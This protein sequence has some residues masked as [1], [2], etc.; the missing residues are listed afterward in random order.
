MGQASDLTCAARPH[1]SIA[2]D[3]IELSN[4]ISRAS[5]VLNQYVREVREARAD[6]DAVSRELHSLQSTLELLKEDA[7]ALPSKVATETPPLL[8]QCNRVVGELDADLLAL[9]GS[10]LSRP[11]KRAQWVSVG[12]HQIKELLPAI[13][14]HR[15]ILA[16]ALD[17]ITM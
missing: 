9:D 16:L 8:Q 7:G 4:T 2:N 6:L 14:V 5:V 10:A 12:K 3:C 1:S 17:L 11:Q 13:A 15:A